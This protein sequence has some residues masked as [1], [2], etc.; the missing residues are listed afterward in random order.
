MWVE[1]LPQVSRE[2]TRRMPTHPRKGLT[3]G[4]LRNIDQ[5]SLR[6]PH[7][8]VLRDLTS[9]WAICKGGGWYRFRSS[10][11]SDQQSA[12]K[13]SWRKYPW[14]PLTIPRT[15]FQN[16][17]DFTKD[18][19]VSRHQCLIFPEI[20]QPFPDFDTVFWS[21]ACCFPFLWGLLPNCPEPWHVAC[22][23]LAGWL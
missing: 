7:V 2:P 11:Q 22:H 4:T 9:W 12:I 16:G 18:K 10:S 5:R 8:T 15:I 1:F 23:F 19:H 20:S 14:F 21:K 17:I 13:T 6:R 3:K